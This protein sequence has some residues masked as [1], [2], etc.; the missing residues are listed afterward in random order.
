MLHGNHF[1]TSSCINQIKT[2]QYLETAD[3]ISIII[4]FDLATLK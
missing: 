3:I 2:S 4:S 1:K